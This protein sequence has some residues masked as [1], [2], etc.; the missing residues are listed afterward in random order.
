MPV[1]MLM[2][3]PEAT[4][5]FYDKVDNELGWEEGEYPDGLIS[6]YAGAHP[7]GGFLV[8]DIWESQEHFGR[9][10]QEELMP[11]ME[12]ASAGGSG[13]EAPRVE[14][15][16]IPIHHQIHATGSARA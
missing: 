14:P 3:A 8:F 2:H 12:R 4:A 9:F 15:K 10:A 5:E 13:G 7:D 11:A 16:F 1:G 6:H